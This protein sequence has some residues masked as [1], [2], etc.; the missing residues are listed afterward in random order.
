MVSFIGIREI[1]GSI[2]SN[3]FSCYF[4]FY[5][6]LIVFT[7]QDSMYVYLSMANIVLLQSTQ[8][9]ITAS[10][11]YNKTP[12]GEIFFEKLCLRGGSHL[13]LP[14]G[15]KFRILKPIPEDGCR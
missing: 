1:K 6:Q 2:K 9:P 11:T 8:K 15:L 13:V 4:G 3:E 7:I 10:G 12:L 14:S 5:I